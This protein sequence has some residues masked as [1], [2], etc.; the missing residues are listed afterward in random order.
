MPHKRNPSNCERLNALSQMA[1]R[2]SDVCRDGMIIEHERDF[3]WHTERLALPH[4]AKIVANMIELFKELLGGLEVKPEKM[5]S[6]IDELMLSE[7]LMITLAQKI[8]RQSA[9]DLVYDS[10]MHAHSTGISFKSIVLK[11]EGIMKHLSQEEVDYAFDP[12]KHIGAAPEIVSNIVSS[13]RRK[14]NHD[15]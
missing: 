1:R 5:L 10:A 15:I 3:G 9:H 6:N 8:G 4:L 14:L 7:P 2:L 13:L 11:K 12:S